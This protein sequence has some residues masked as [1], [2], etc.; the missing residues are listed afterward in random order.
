MHSINQPYL[1]SAWS[2]AGENR[3]GTAIKIVDGPTDRIPHQR[4]FSSPGIL[5]SGP[6]KFQW[7]K[8]TPLSWRGKESMKSW[9]C[10]KLF[11]KQCIPCLGKAYVSS[12]PAAIWHALISL[13]IQI[14]A[15]QRWVSSSAW[16]FT[17]FEDIWVNEAAR[18]HTEGWRN[19]TGTST[20]FRFSKQ[21]VWWDS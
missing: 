20:S 10:R 3:C 11:P 2:Y 4:D 17:D 12:N 7:C 21:S 9:D 6:C 14:S 13:Q 1:M 8:I 16:R 15:R 18:L 19:Q 5:W